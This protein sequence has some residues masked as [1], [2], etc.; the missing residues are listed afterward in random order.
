MNAPNAEITP[1]RRGRPPAE[2]PLNTSLHVKVTEGQH[3]RLDQFAR[4][5]GIPL[6]AFVRQLLT[7]RFDSRL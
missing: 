1:K 6:A 7:V 5:H 3:D 2:Q 4:R